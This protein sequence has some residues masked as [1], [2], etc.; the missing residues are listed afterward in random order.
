MP[1]AP[2]HLH[3]LSPGSTL[4]LGLEQGTG[5]N[6]PLAQHR[7]AVTGFSGDGTEETDML[8]RPPHPCPC[9]LTH[10]HTYMHSNTQVPLLSHKTPTAVTVRL[11]EGRG[12]FAFSFDMPRLPGSVT[13]LNFS[14]WRLVHVGHIHNVRNPSAPLSRE[15]EGDSREI[16]RKQSS[17]RWPCPWCGGWNE[18]IF[19]VPSNTNQSMIL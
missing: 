12:S 5:G 10:M 15:E 8:P 2:R 14:S 1:P 6:H 4:A 16:P 3:C 18:M 13:Q 17:G 19:K 11:S 7:W 9:T